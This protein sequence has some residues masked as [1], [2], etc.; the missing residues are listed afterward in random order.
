ML[1]SDNF[2]QLQIEK[3]VGNLLDGGLEGI[4]RCCFVE[5]DSF[6]SFPHLPLAHATKIIKPGEDDEGRRW[7]FETNFLSCHRDIGMI[8]ILRVELIVVTHGG[9]WARYDRR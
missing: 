9:D 2:S 3:E 5:V 1:K 7:R 4:E 6:R 8:S